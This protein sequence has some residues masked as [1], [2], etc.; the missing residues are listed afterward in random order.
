M[1]AAVGPETSELLYTIFISTKTSALAHALFTKLREKRV[2]DDGVSL[3]DG[4]VPLRD[5]CHRHGLEFRYEQHENRNSIKY[6][7]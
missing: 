7:F 2:V 6:V 5:T 3:I 1:Y 4:A